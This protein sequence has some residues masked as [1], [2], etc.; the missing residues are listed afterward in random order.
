M[1]FIRLLSK[2]KIE[3]TILIIIYKNLSLFNN[4]FLNI[5]LNNF[6]NKDLYDSFII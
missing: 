5:L 3:I 2:Y 6:E 4:Y 1:K